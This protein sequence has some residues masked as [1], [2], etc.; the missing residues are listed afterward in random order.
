MKK[1]QYLIFKLNQ[2]F[3]CW[4]EWEQLKHYGLWNEPYLSK[5]TKCGHIAETIY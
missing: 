1:I 5:C 4:H 2:W 3:F